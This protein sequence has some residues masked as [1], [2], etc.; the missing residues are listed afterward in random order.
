MTPKKV[1]F[2]DIDGVLNCS[3]TTSRIGVHPFVDDNKLELLHDIVVSTGAKIVLSSSWRFGAF[4]TATPSERM[5]LMELLQAFR[6]HGLEMWHSVTPASAEG[7]LHRGKEIL[8]WLENNSG[9]EKWVAV[10]DV[11]DD[12]EGVMDRAVITTWEKG[13]TPEL[14]IKVIKML[15]EGD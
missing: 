4:N 15:N 6:N 11:A 1:I 2:L 14:A 7:C 13:L 3:T 8:K 12:L 9:V 10:D 5:F